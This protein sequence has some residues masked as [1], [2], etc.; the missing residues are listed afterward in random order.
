VD[1]LIVIYVPP[2]VTGAEEVARA[3]L[4]SARVLKGRKPLLT[5]FMQAR[6]VPEGLSA[7]DVR[8]P[9]YAF[10]ESAAIALARAV[11]YGEWLTRPDAEPVRME[12]LDRDR[13]AAAIEGAAERGDAWLS[14]EDVWTVLSSYGLPLVEQRVCRTVD[15]VQR[16]AQELDGE[17]ALKGQAAGLVHKTEA[18]A[19][20]LRLSAATV[21]DAARRMEAR[22]SEAGHGATTF[23]VQKMAPAGL[24]MIVGAVHDPEFGPVLACGAGGTLVE[25]LKDVTV[26]IAPVAERDAREMVAELKTYPA[27]TGYRGAPPRDVDA[28]V[29]VILRVGW[30]VDD[31]QEIQE[32]DLNPVLVHERGATVVDA[33]VRIRARGGG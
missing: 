4:D 20:E 27:L 21:G 14:A 33:R 11:R 26:R 2:L 32:L 16:A 25:L 5:V 29:D 22:L 7:P 8:I 9:S 15:E 28:L 1:S 13:A 18:G 10:P 3:I 31:L 23:T 24:E 17:L 12:G 6:G 19:V 30:L